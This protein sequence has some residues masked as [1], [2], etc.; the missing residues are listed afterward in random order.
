MDYL[1]Q[2]T[3]ADSSASA[4]AASTQ[5]GIQGRNKNAHENVYQA[6]MIQT[7]KIL[8]RQSSKQYLKL[9]LNK[10]R[11]YMSGNIYN[12]RAGRILAS[13]CSCLVQS[14]IKTEAFELLFDDV[15]DNLSKIKDQQVAR[16]FKADERGDIESMWN[17]QIFAELMKAPGTVSLAWLDS[18]SS[19]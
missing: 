5:F 10:L 9:I 6:H 18:I 14:G 19:K 7:L 3:S 15:Y 4:Q 12:T 1:A 17:L 2:D 8:I 13:M 16:N 11:N